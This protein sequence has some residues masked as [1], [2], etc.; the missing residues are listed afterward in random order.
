MPAGR[1]RPGPAPSSWGSVGGLPRHAL[2]ASPPTAPRAWPLLRR[3]AAPPRAGSR[4]TRA[5]RGAGSDRGGANAN[6]A[7][8]RRGAGNAKLEVPGSCLQPPTVRGSLSCN[9]LAAEPLL[10]GP[11]PVL[12]SAAKHSYRVQ[13]LFKRAAQRVTLNRAPVSPPCCPHTR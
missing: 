10:P 4:A 8:L 6:H 13:R 3:P 11:L 1:P 9:V 2:R 5:N 12:L 7:S